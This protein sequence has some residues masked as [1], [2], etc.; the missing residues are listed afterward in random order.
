M[1]CLQIQ[2]A[3]VL[4]KQ[5]V[6]LRKQKT[7][8]YGASARVSSVNTQ[9]KVWNVGLGKSCRHGFKLVSKLWYLA[10]GS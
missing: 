1:P 6:N 4:A 8:M 3:T 9:A 5:L 2:A 10:E 7:R